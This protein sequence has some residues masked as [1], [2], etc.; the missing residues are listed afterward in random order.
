MSM[1]DNMFVEL[2]GYVHPEDYSWV[3]EEGTVIF[4]TAYMSSGVIYIK[5]QNN[6]IRRIPNDTIALKTN[7][8]QVDSLINLIESG[9]LLDVLMQ[10]KSD[11]ERAFYEIRKEQH[12]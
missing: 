2:K 7:W 5:I 4:R 6:K 8:I 9:E 3:R 1:A 11:K 12:K 10:F